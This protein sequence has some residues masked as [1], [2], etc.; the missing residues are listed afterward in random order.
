MVHTDTFTASSVTRDRTRWITLAGE[1]DLATAP[2][3]RHELDRARAGPTRAVV[4]DLSGL[5]F[6]DCAALRGVIKFADGARA[7]GW[8]LQIVSPP[9]PVAQIFTLTGTD[10]LLPLG[11]RPQRG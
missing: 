9:P 10:E 2:A 11:G 6:M 3:L 1:L 8:R 4:L 5:R 7:R